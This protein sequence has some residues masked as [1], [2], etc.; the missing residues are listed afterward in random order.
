[1]I[2]YIRNLT[3][4]EFYYLEL[5]VNSPYF[6]TNKNIVRLFNYLKKIYPDI[7]EEDLSKENI[8]LNVFMSKKVN[9]VNFRKLVSEFSFFMEG[10][11]IQLEADSDEMRNRILLL[12]SLR[13]R[14]LVKRYNKYYK[15][16]SKLFRK[17]FQRMRSTI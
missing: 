17:V 8:S 10:F 5:A 4:E 11:F 12:K 14:G 16:I 7:S 3:K 2:E 9:E 15:E 6:T 13:N 1:M